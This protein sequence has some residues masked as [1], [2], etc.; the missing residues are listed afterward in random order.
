A[1]GA[2]RAVRVPSAGA[3][4]CTSGLLSGALNTGTSGGL[5]TTVVATADTSMG[6]I[7]FVVP[8]L[9]GLKRTIG[10][11]ERLLPRQRRS[12]PIDGEGG[13]QDFIRIVRIGCGAMRPCRGSPRSKPLSW[14]ACIPC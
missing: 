11:F 6:T 13:T 1:N 9:V 12:I 8:T 4:F 5:T 14:C 10:E 7:L 3:P 2:G